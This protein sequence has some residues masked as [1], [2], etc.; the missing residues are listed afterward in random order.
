MEPIDLCGSSSSSAG[1]SGTASRL[2]GGH[3]RRRTPRLAAAA[4]LDPVKEKLWSAPV[5]LD[6]SEPEE[7][8]KAPPAKPVRL[9]RAAT[10]KRTR[11]TADNKD[12]SEELD[13][14]GTRKEIKK[15]VSLPEASE[16]PLIKEPTAPTVTTVTTQTTTTTIETQETQD[17]LCSPTAPVVKPGGWKPLKKKDSFFS[18]PSSSTES[19]NVSSFFCKARPEAVIKLVQEVVS[20]QEKAAKRAKSLQPVKE[21]N[22]KSVEQMV[23]QVEPEAVEEPVQVVEEKPSWA[24][25]LDDHATIEERRLIDMAARMEPR[26]VSALPSYI[27]YS[28]T[29]TGPALSDIDPALQAALQQSIEASKDTE[30]GL[31]DMPFIIEVAAKLIEQDLTGDTATH[32]A[33][34]FK[35]SNKT[36]F[37]NIKTIYC[38]SRK[39]SPRGLLL[40]HKD[41]PLFDSVKVSASGLEPEG[42]D[43]KIR[44]VLYDKELFDK[45]K[46]E[47]QKAKAATMEILKEDT[48][49]DLDVSAYMQ[50]NDSDDGAHGNSH[51]SDGLFTIKVIAGKKSFEEFRISP[52]STL[53]ELLELFLAKHPETP[54]ANARFIFDGDVLQLTKTIKDAELEDGDQLELRS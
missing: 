18:T 6:F 27:S 8:L 9:A 48:Q 3:V 21:Q 30:E 25:F 33:L 28:V 22:V 51:S 24:K 54:K 23:K 20:E 13:Q 46:D 31:V 5:L 50:D 36:N 1:N 4:A 16:K 39:I 44:L 7:A 52:T 10:F 29:P 26:K 47:K 15:E 53:A 42:I 38:N 49:E 35:I 32:K 45:M 2:A 40:T 14:K 17:T 11:A 43:G 19:C 41:V 37:G 12:E 34:S